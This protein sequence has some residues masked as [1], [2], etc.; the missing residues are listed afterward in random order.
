[1]A[2]PT[3]LHEYAQRQLDRAETEQLSAQKRLEVADAGAKAA[4]ESLAIAMR[5]RE[6]LQKHEA[7]VR[8]ALPVIPTAAEGD[9]LVDELELITIG[10]RAAY[11][12]VLDA[13]TALAV[14][15]AERTRAADARARAQQAV[16]AAKALLKTAVERGGRLKEMGAALAGLAGIVA[17]A[18]N[19]KTG[20]EF[21]AAEGRIDGDFPATLLAHARKRLQRV[22]TK[23]EQ[24]EETASAV[25]SQASDT[26]IEISGTDAIL[27]GLWL[28]LRRADDAVSTYVAT[29]Q[30]RYDRASA[31]LKRIP[32]A[33]PLT[34]KEIA[35]IESL[36]ADAATLAAEVDAVDLDT[37]S[38]SIVSLAGAFAQTRLAAM[39]KGI[40]PDGLIAAADGLRQAT[41]AKKEAQDKVNTAK[42]AVQDATD[43]SAEADPEEDQAVIDAKADLAA[44]STALGDAEVAANEAAATLDAAKVE[45]GGGAVVDGLVDAYAQ[46]KD[47]ENEAAAAR[48]T[49]D[50]K[51]TAWHDAEATY[52]AAKAA[53]AD[54][55][56]AAKKKG[57]EPENDAEVQA[58]KTKADAALTKLEE[59][60]DAYRSSGRGQLHIWE[61]ALPDGAWQLL[62]DFEEATSLLDELGSGP[63]VLTTEQIDA[64]GALIAELTKVDDSKRKAVLLGREKLAQAALSEALARDRAARFLAA[65][66][67]DR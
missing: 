18:D 6:H 9:A 47:A 45:V 67:G 53:L 49:W 32:A 28:R 24:A 41:A 23:L 14:A 2:D 40:D 16:T 36:E 15:D 38:G 64:E 29:A 30:E 31:S 42:Q 8:K 22:R 21:T 19:A 17:S 27:A 37:S 57:I 25:D 44:K 48:Q 1:M 51:E 50:E 26:E 61:V 65:L 58:A 54:A 56:A 46:L 43:A 7:A 13:T 63:D 4:R 59:A 39:V 10:R 11:A 52:A 34:P 62:A 5:R 55:E 20:A 35:Q 3:P 60:I 33:T 66:R 12:A